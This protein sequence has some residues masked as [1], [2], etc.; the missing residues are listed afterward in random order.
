MTPRIYRLRDVIRV[1]GFARST[2]Y[3]KISQGK[4]PAPFKSADGPRG[5]LWAA[6]DVDQHVL[7]IIRAGKSTQASPAA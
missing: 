1:T 5:N 6:D 3:L 4:F 7:N 2:L